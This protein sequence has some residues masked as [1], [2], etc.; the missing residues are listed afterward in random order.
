MRLRLPRQPM[1]QPQHRAQA[2]AI[3]MHMRR[4]HERIAREQ[5]I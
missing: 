5:E 4:Q 1:A 2:I 3:C